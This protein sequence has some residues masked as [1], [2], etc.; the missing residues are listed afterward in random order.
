MHYAF[1][2]GKKTLA[3]LDGEQASYK[4]TKST[5]IVVIM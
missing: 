2:Q 4:V 3:L 1:I 5:A